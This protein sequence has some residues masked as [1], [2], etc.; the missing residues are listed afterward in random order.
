VSTT[1]YPTPTAHTSN[2]L[3]QV[4]FAGPLYF[5]GKRQ[6]DYFLTK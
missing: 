1:T 5:K 6:R 4:D 3:H 2:H